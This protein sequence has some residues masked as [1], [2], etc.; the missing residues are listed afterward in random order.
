MKKLNDVN[1]PSSNANYE[2]IEEKKLKILKLSA[3]QETIFRDKKNIYIFFF[4]RHC[5]CINRN[6]FYKARTRAEPDS[7]LSI[8]QSCW[9]FIMLLYVKIYYCRSKV[10]KN[11]G[12][13][14]S[15][16]YVA[17]KFEFSNFFEGNNQSLQFPSKL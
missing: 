15:I 8:C 1:K 6:V 5:L 11:E 17:E 3:I 7:R 14:D 9:W 16:K 4:L 2:K 10:F 13:D 12:N